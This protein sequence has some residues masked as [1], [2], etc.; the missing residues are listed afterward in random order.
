M[1]LVLYEKLEH[2]YGKPLLDAHSVEMP[3]GTRLDEL[4]V[5]YPVVT[6][7]AQLKP[8]TYYVFGEVSSLNLTLVEPEDGKAH[9]FAFEFI[10]TKNFSGLSLTPEP[11]WVVE[12]QW[13]AGKT[14]QVSILRGVGVALCV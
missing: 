2:Y 11:K 6:E 10:P 8:E 13:A 12:P 3:D 14:C 5:S 1:A 4:S 9:E 7:G